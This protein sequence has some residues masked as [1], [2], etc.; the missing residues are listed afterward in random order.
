[1][2]AMTRHPP[3][4]QLGR[5][6][7]GGLGVD[8]RD[9][10]RC[11]LPGERTHDALADAQRAARDQH[12]LPSNSPISS[13]P[14]LQSPSM[15]NDRHLLGRPRLQMDLS[16][17]RRAPSAAGA[18]GRYHAGNAC[19]AGR[20]PSTCPPPIPTPRRPREAADA[21]AVDTHGGPMARIPIEM[22]K[23][24]YDMETGTIAAWVKQV[25][26]TVAAAMCSPRSRPRSRRWRWRRS[27]A[28]RSWSRPW[29][30]AR[31][32]PSARSSG[33]SRTVSSARSDE[34][35]GAGMDPCRSAD[36]GCRDLDAADRA[37]PTHDDEPC[38]SATGPA[39]RPSC[40]CATG[41]SRRTSRRPPRRPSRARRSRAAPR[42]MGRILERFGVGPMRPRRP[43]GR[44]RRRSW[45]SCSPSRA[46][47]P[48]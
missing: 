19:V 22:P 42:P 9:R 40:R 43:A 48:W 21:P 29:R 31:R 15:R 47:R 23:L 20:V 35:N 6:D 8:V 46:A 13:L 38:A 7:L 17:P 28:A 32:C 30:P 25:G 33:I 16:V 24:G 45:S 41:A 27:P 1:M 2:T 12:A 5:Q 39:P 11:S 14:S 34:P 3:R 26:D 37:A 36:A 18:C 4:G 44:R 10:H